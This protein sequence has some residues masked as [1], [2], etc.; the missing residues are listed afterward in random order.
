[1][2]D[3]DGLMGAIGWYSTFSDMQAQ[4]ETIAAARA[5]SSR[6]FLSGDIIKIN[7]SY[8][9]APKMKTTLDLQWA[10]I[11]ILALSGAAG[12]P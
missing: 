4:Y 6:K 8:G 9:K 7:M 5:V 3:I 2:Y 11:W 10:S 12:A 1:M